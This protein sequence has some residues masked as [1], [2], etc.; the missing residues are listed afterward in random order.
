MVQD[1]D[2][3]EIIS[4]VLA[5]M[6]QGDKLSQDF[7]VEQLKELNEDLSKWDSLN[8]KEKME[9]RSALKE[10]M[11]MNEMGKIIRNFI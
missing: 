8:T 2:M 11:T 10:I 3:E 9:I 4:N 6:K 7:F 1:N 5:F